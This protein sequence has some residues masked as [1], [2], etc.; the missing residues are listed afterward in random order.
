MAME[1]PA[2]HQIE[3]KMSYDGSRFYFC[4]T[5]RLN[6]AASMIDLLIFPAPVAQALSI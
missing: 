3:L 1:N 4:L 6:D 2:A 5:A